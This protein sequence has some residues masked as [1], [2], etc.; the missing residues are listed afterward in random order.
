VIRADPRIRA[1]VEAGKALDW[2]IQ[3]MTDHDTPPAVLA[4]TREARALVSD[5]ARAALREEA[6]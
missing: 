5:A 4:W 2:A 1:L 6:K 3:E